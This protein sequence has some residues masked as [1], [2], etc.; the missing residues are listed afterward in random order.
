MR[1]EKVKK[2]MESERESQEPE[3]GD[4]KPMAVVVAVV[5]M[6]TLREEQVDRI[7][8]SRIIV[9]RDEEFQVEEHGYY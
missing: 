1:K 7:I 2:A 4:P 5:T 9:K 8:L 3:P 6:S